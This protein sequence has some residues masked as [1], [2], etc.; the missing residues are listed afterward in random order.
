MIIEEFEQQFKNRKVIL[1]RAVDNK[2]LFRHCAENQD[3]VTMSKFE[4]TVKP[5]LYY[6]GISFI[7]YIAM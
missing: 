6:H 4:A 5:L 2:E 3:Y 7:K 1:V